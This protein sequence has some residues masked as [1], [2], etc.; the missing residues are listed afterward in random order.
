M[1]DNDYY[2]LWFPYWDQQYP[3]YYGPWH[4]QYTVPIIPDVITDNKGWICPKCDKVYS[5]K[6][7]QCKECNNG[8]G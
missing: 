4:P 6:V 8:N 2:P 1:S 5:P 7:K 3:N